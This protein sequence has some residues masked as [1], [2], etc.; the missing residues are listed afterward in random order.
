M[1]IVF[2][3]TKA[4]CKL[5]PVFELAYCNVPEES[6]PLRK[7]VID[8][9][10][11]YHFE[12]YNEETGQLL[13]YIGKVVRVCIQYNPNHAF[14]PLDATEEDIR[15]LSILVDCSSD[16]K[17]EVKLI[18]VSDLRTVEEYIDPDV[19]PEP[20]PDPETIKILSYEIKVLTEDDEPIEGIEVGDPYLEIYIEGVDESLRIPLM[21][22][23]TKYLTPEKKEVT[24]T[25]ARFN[26]LGENDPPIEGVKVGERYVELF[27]EGELEPIIYPY[28]YHI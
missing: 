21:W 28:P 18:N 13:D 10:K 14:I 23:I 3:N 20:T 16:C 27:I 6:D 26:V 17:S 1:P 5:E 8:R 4:F 15:I 9:N 11:K 2:L 12:A 25:S 7:V 24:I 22:I 19:D